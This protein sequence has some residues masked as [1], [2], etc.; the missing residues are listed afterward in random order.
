[1]LANKT[2]PKGRTIMTRKPNRI[3]WTAA[4][5]AALLISLLPAPAAAQR[6]TVPVRVGYTIFENYQEGRDG[7]YKR[8]F[9]YEYLQRV[10][11]ITD[12]EYEYVYGTFSELMQMLQAGEIDL[13]GNISYTEERARTIHYSKLPQGRERFY[14]YTTPGQERIDPNDLSTLNG[15]RI[16]VTAG[17][18][19]YGLLLQWLEENQY[20]CTLGEYTGTAA[21]CDAL[22]AG[23][24]DAV[25][26]TDMAS[27][28]GF[29]PVV[30]I[31]FAEFYFGVNR[32]RPDLL[33]QLNKAMMEIQ[34]ID[35]YYNEK[36]YAKYSTT[37]LSN[38]HL[39]REERDWLERH[40]NTVRLGYL[41]DNLPY[42]DTAEDGSLKGL[43]TVLVQTFTEDFGIRAEAI[44]FASLDAM[45]QA[46][47]GGEIDLFGPMFADCWLAEQNGLFPT[48]SFSNTT[49]ILLYQGEYEEGKTQ[50]ISFSGSNAVQKGAAQVLYPEAALVE[51]QSTE[52]SLQAVLDGRAGCTIVSSATLNL[53][54][55]YKAMD[56]LNML[57]LP[58]AADICLATVRGNY[59]LL[60]ITNRVV[61][62][63]SEDLTGVALM[64]NLRN[65]TSLSL[66]EFVQ[67]HALAVIGFL[68][69]VIALLIGWVV[70]YVSTNRRIARMRTKNEELSQQAFRDGLTKVGNR[71][72]YFSEEM[73]LQRKIDAGEPLS[74]GLVMVDVNGLK[75]VNDSLG[76][77]Y[78]DRLICNASRL[79][80]RIYD[81]SPVFRIGGDEFV[82]V[83]TNGDYEQREELLAKLA[84][85][86]LPSVGKE[87]LMRS[88]ASVAF[89]MAVFD[90]SHDRS[91]EAVFERADKAMYECKKQIKHS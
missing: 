43:L 47:Q 46:A 61:F 8:G 89:G 70:F 73:K 44:P 60:N 27:H 63:S 1:M 11:Y 33:A 16:G 41:I 58:A 28:R 77:E 48:D 87:Q 74:F 19:Q 21:C 51:C 38:T 4:V 76:H 62:A 49:C 20:D 2:N 57:E 54:L 78:G 34:T 52:D 69:G 36:V 59:E 25:V 53:L 15:C 35:P 29:L 90:N 10:S 64:E 18:Y 24:V 31:G 17:S 67:Q 42:C 9:G 79:I 50:T 14:L 12:W 80:C 81:H 86:N 66:L 6:E 7:E 55:R 23:E 5:V 72:G 40:N 65:D 91:V 85:N 75:A 45:V 3:L 32:A 71:A 13:M 84:E 56:S 88:G 22:T 26:M 39:N 83:L 30:N 82:V 68:L 37:S